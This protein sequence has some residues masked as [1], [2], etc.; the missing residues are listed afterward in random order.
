[1]TSA[2]VRK[3]EI[4]S[5]SVESRLLNI[6]EQVIGARDSHTEEIGDDNSDNAFCFNLL[7]NRLSELE[8]QII[9]KDAIIDFLANQLVNKSPNGDFPI[10]KTVNDHNNSFQ[11]RV[12]NTVNNKLPLVQYNNEK[13]KK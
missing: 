9:E 1:M 5:K 7:K 10:N 4:F 11:E 13:E 6:E 2:L 3:F 8:R 12:D